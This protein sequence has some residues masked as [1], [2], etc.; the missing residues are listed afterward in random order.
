MLNLCVP[1]GRRMDDWEAEVGERSGLK[2][3]PVH[4]LPWL[5]ERLL[6]SEVAQASV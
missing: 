5:L 1:E 4:V 2:V 3:L 6:H